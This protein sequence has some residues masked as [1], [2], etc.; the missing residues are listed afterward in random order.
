MPILIELLITLIS[1]VALLVPIY[2]FR[3]HKSKDGCNVPKAEGCWPILGH[4]PLFSSKDLLIHKKLGSMAD[5]YGPIFAL[6]LG[7]HRAIVVSSWEV[8]KEIF[9]VHDKAFSDR[10]V[11]TAT[12]LLGYDG[13]MLG[14]APYGEYWREI[15][16]IGTIDLLSKHRLDSL[17]DIRALEVEMAIKDLFKSWI[18]K[19]RPRSGVLVEMKSWL[20]DLMLNILSKLVGG[21]R[22][23]GSNADCDEMEAERCKTL[24]RTF[25]E[26]LGVLVVSDAFPALGWLD[27]GGYKRL[28]K[29][30]AKELDI[31]AQGWLEDHRRKRL[32]RPAGDREQNFMD[33]MLKDIEGANLSGFDADTVI[34]ATCLNMIVAG[35][36]T[37]MV[38]STWVLSLLVNNRGVLKKAQ[39]ELEVHVGKSRPVEE[40][41]VKNLTYLQAIVKETMRL[42]PPGP[43]NALRTTM[44]ECTFSGGFRVPAGTRLMLNIWKMQRDGRVWS[45]PDKF[46]PERFLTTHQNVDVRGRNLELIPFGAGRRSCAGMSLALHTVH[47][48][49]ASLLQSFDIGAVSDEAM[50]MTESPGLSNMKAT[51]LEV[52]LIPRL[53]PKFYERD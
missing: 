10:P 21:K 45:N 31:L 20:G 44:E 51:L 35:S 34:K 36:D 42:Y 41:D 1:T 27:I 14:F 22:Y 6:R 50:D 47:L 48:T 3:R 18:E 11:I 16:K 15:R 28:M 29:E 5:K 43:V 26:L 13:A 17:K 40:S 37:L 38:A 19:G 4:I 33:L 8:A 9:T 23:S 2:L 53:D 7:S 25:F 52:T 49:V 30:T 32:S 46:E 39:Q 24:M 12:K